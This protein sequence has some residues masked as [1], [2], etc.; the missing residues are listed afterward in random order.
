MIMSEWLMKDRI[1]MIT[2]A[3][4]GIGKITALELAKMDARIIMVCRNKNKGIQAQREILEKTGNPDIDLMVADLSSQASIR[5]FADKFEE[6][7]DALHILIQNAGTMMK[8]RIVTADGLE[9]TFATN[10]LGPFLLTNLLL[11][12]LTTSAPSRIISIS[13]GMH[14]RASIDLDDLQSTKTYRNIN[15][16]SMSKLAN[17][18]FIYELH[19]RLQN[20]GVTN[21]TANVV[22][23]GFVRTNFGMNG[24]NWFYKLGMKIIHPFLAISPQE[25][26]ETSIY[27]AS[28]PEVENISGKYFAQKKVSESSSLTHDR[29]LQKNLWKISEELTGLSSKS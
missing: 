18:L 7:Y 23:P 8:K 11:D 25:G 3:N 16:Y 22:H 2:G 6:K 20:S 29:N 21:V 15:V 26:A 9:T 28:S 14:H 10:H 1:C 19:H 4:S 5:N 27:V 13:S 12:I 24:L 17:I